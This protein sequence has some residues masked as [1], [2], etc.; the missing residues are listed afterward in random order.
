M[1]VLSADWVALVVT[2]LGTLFL[3]GEL[4]VN[5]KGFFG[6]LGFGFITVYF[7]SVVEPSMVFIMMLIYFIGLVLV[8]IDGK[9]LN[10]GTLAVIGTVCM[11]LSVGLSAPNWIAGSYAILG[12]LIGALSSFFFLKVFKRR[13]MWTKMALMDR[14]T[15]D[16]GYSTMNVTYEELVDQ[17]G[18][19]L[20]D[21]RP[22]GTIRIRGQEY[23]AISNGQWMKKGSNI[24]VIH[25]DGTKILVS[26]LNNGIS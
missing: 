15:A 17:E 19:T 13:N 20:T 4:L 21:M 11:I 18:V 23:S 2:G 1:E 22:V 7:L 6:L 12:V 9:L 3:F 10:D 16:K 5:M 14:L 25:V 24:K 26:K 8:I